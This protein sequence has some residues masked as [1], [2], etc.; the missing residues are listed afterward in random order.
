M[1]L[2]L[3][4]WGWSTGFGGLSNFSATN[5]SFTGSAL[6]ATTTVTA[7]DGFDEPFS[8]STNKIDYLEYA[9]LQRLRPQEFLRQ[10]PVP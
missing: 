6:G 1:N 9:P 10:W 7:L 4:W 8:T 5:I 3:Q 2:N